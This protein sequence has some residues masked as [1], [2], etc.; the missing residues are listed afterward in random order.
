[1]EAHS[2]ECPGLPHG[3]DQQVDSLRGWGID[4]VPKEAVEA[5]DDAW[6]VTGFKGLHQAVAENIQGHI[7]IFRTTQEAAKFRAVIR[8]VAETA[9]LQE[10]DGAR[11]DFPLADTV[12]RFGGCERLF[13]MSRCEVA[14]G[15]C[16]PT[17]ATQNGARVP[18]FTDAEA[19]DGSI[20][21]IARDDGGRKEK[22]LGL[23][24]NPQSLP[25]QPVGKENVVK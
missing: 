24:T 8:V 9:G 17:G 21:E 7:Q 19:I 5:R 16:A 11:R 3:L 14:G 13:G 10:G 23:L 18:W 12:G 4:L 25:V 22:D 2:L 20:R 15:G 1:M 6:S